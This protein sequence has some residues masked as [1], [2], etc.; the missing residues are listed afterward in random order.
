MS[1]RGLGSGGEHRTVARV[2][3]ILEVV[4]RSPA[5]VRLTRLADALDAPKSSVFSLV[6]GLVSSGYL[7]E[8]RATY[9]LGPAVYAL[10]DVNRPSLAQIA[11][12][13]L[14][15]LQEE[16][17][18]TVML[19]TQVGDSVVYLSKIES[20][21]LIRY[22]AP[23]RTR[24]PLWPTSTGKCL[25]AHLPQRRR[26]RLLSNWFANDGER[27]RVDAELAQFG[28]RGSPLCMTKCTLMSVPSPG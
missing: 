4:A 22:S 1:S 7:A 18:E 15:A 2:T 21:Q 5:G 11:K 28:S 3:M 13:Y 14:V 20:S 25:L 27:F 9:H 23:L 6:K 19:A 8:D 12:P 16:Y 26:D 10:L 17:D 24:R